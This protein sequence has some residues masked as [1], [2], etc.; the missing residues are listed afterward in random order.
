MVYH[1]VS[2]RYGVLRG[3]TGC[4]TVLQCVTRFEKMLHGVTLCYT[5]YHGVTRFCRV[6]HGITGC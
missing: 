5:V 4:Y 6:L 2:G 3:L 1:G